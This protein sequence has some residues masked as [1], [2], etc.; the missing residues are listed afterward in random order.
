M[1][2]I[3]RIL[4]AIKDPAARSVPALMKAAQLAR[5]LGA[6]LELFHALDWPLYAS[7]YLYNGGHGLLD[8]KAKLEDTVTQR[9]TALARSIRSRPR[10]PPLH[11]SIA[12][13]WDAPGYEAV[14]RRARSIKADLIV[15][16]PHRGHRLLPMLHFN[17]WELLRRS[18][19]PVLLVKRRGLYARPVVLAAVDPM[20]RQDRTARLDR[21]ILDNGETLAQA[22]HGQLHSVHAYVLVPA[23]MG[24]VD[25]LDVETATALNHKIAV[26]AQ[27]RFSWLLRDYSV[28]ERCR[29]LLARPAA[30]AI[31]QTARKTHSAIVT[32]GVVA[33]SGWR[34][35]LIGRTAERLLDRLPCD[36]LVVKPPNFRIAIAREPRRLQIIAAPVRP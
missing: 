13:A 1:H 20:H 23:R 33:R 4:I 35:L 31:E 29:H 7:P 16:E 26:S 6:K 10:Q 19:I 28:P 12:A 9:L 5:S 17:D 24:A 25:A 32:L 3:S 14:I 2:S 36:L 30:D 8:L 11:V 15:A 21:A 18:P 27:R 34:Q 22:L